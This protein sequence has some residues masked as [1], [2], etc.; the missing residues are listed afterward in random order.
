MQRW[1][2]IG[3]ASLLI[4]LA[5]CT[6]DKPE[7]NENA[8]EETETEE[9]T[10]EATGK[11]DGDQTVDVDKGLLNVEITLPASMFEGEDIDAV[12]EEAKKE[13]VAEVTQNEDGSL[14][15]KMSKAQHREM[16]DE[17]EASITQSIEEIKTSEDYVSI[18]DITYDPSFTAFTLLVDKKAYE[19]SMDGF[20]GFSLGM[21]GMMYQMYNGENPDTSKVTI[22]VKD[23]AT[24]EV[25]DEMVF[26]DDMEETEGTDPE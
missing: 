8:S 25:F 22:Q 17:L 16:M 18:Q 6:A 24:Q 1:I 10:E 14:T 4:F 15:Y 7:N 19:N 23:E 5:A 26:P 13:G 2:Y 3:I 20:V 12:M 9:Q 21:S 11:Q